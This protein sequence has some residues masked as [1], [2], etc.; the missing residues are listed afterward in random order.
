METKEQF[1][2]FFPAEALY[3]IYRQHPIICTD[4]RQLTPGCIFF[5]LTGENFNGNKFALQALESGAA[6]CV[7]DDPQLHDTTTPNPRLL[8]VADVLESLQVLANRRR[9]DFDIPI[10]AIGGSNGKTTTKEL[11]TA[12]MSSHYPCHATKGNLNNHIGVPL[13]LLA[14]PD[15]TEVAIIEMGTNQP[16]DIQLLCQIAEPTHGLITNIGKE[17]L[18]GFGSIEGVKKAEGELFEYLKESAG[19]AFVNRSERYLAAMSREVNHHVDYARTQNLLPVDPSTITVELFEET[20]FVCAAFLSDYGQRIEVQTRLLGTHN[21][22][23]IMTAIALG[24]YFKVPAERIKM[25]LENYQPSNNRSQLVQRGSNTILLDAYN[26]NPSSMVP[27]LETLR[28][29][30]GTKKVAMLGDMLELGADSLAEHEAILHFA[31]QLRLDHLVLVGP[32]FGRTAWSSAGALHFPDAAAARIWFQ[33]QSFEHTDFL[34]KGSRGI[35]METVV[36]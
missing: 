30:K 14:M 31:A 2:E 5:A 36:A 3:Q 23:N 15:D 8:L 25:A 20:P 1:L 21:F 19:C 32:E 35:R 6:Y 34:V 17:H 12:V 18:E 13:T 11:L 4:T 7:A 10:I 24:L 26:A 22:N 16:G 33:S 29:M 28:K 9:K 27:A